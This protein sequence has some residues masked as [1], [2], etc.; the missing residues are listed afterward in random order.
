MASYDVASTIHQSLAVGVFT[1]D[2]SLLG[3]KRLMCGGGGSGG[4][5]GGRELADYC[6]AALHECMT[7]E[8][9]AALPAYVD[10]HAEVA[11]LL[12][13]ASRGS[14]GGRGFRSSTF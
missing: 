6:R 7:R 3:F 4:G 13:A 14:D 2:P 8:E 10:L 12:A 9:P 5:G 1:S 11:S